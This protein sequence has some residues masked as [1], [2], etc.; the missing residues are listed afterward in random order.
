MPQT[1]RSSRWGQPAW[2]MQAEIQLSIISNPSVS[3]NLVFF[4][5]FLSSH[6]NLIWIKKS[7]SDPT[8]VFRLLGKTKIRKQETRCRRSVPLWG[9][10]TRGI[11]GKL[12]WRGAIVAKLA[13]CFRGHLVLRFERKPYHFPR[14]FGYDIQVDREYLPF[15]VFQLVT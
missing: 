3:T 11:P 7:V 5:T 12:H 8:E 6:Q 9:G 2:I 4:M 14:L 10:L 15:F 1:S 13:V